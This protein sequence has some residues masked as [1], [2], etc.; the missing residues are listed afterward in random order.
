[1][2]GYFSYGKR[3]KAMSDEKPTAATPHPWDLFEAQTE[4][5]PTSK[6]Y[7]ARCAVCGKAAT[8]KKAWFRSKD[9]ATLKLRFNFAFC[10]KCG[11]WV[12]GDCFYIYTGN[13]NGDDMCTACAKERG[14]TGWTQEQYGD[15]ELRFRYQ[16]RA[17]HKA[18]K[19]AMRKANEQ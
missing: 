12:C 13:G 19:R 18:V 15:A 3:E 7:T 5:D 8:Q 1:M 6:T 9:A 16:Y 17:R 2:G 4:Y 14:K 11:K 10:E